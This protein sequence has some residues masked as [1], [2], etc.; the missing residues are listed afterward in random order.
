[1]RNE[2]VILED[3]NDALSK[4][5]AVV[6]RIGRL[7]DEMGETIEY[8]EEQQIARNDAYAGRPPPT[9]ERR[10]DES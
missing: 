8:N 10:T 5:A 4:Q 1:M 9:R 6:E 3:L 2:R 7:V